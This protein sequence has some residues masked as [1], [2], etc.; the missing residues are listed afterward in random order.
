MVTHFHAGSSLLL[1]F[2][3]LYMKEIILYESLFFGVNTAII[4]TSLF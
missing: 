4:E 1:S 2:L 3:L